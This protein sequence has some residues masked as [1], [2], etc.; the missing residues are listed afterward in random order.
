M[1]RACA[2]LGKNKESSYYESWAAKA[3]AEFAEEYVSS[4]GRLV[5]DTQTAYSLAI[6]FDLLKDSQLSRAGAQLAEIVR[7]NAF[8]VGTGFAGTPFVCEAL[9]RTGHSNVAY[10]MLLNETCPSWLYTISM[11]ATTTWERWDSM[12]PDGSINPGE[13]TSFN[14]YAYGAVAKFM[15][16]RLAGLQQLEPGWKRCRVQPEIG[17]EFTWASASHLTPYGTVSS[18]WKLVEN[19]V[20]AGTFSLSVD[21]EVPPS[22]TME[23]VLPSAEGPKTQ[24]V[25]SGKWS[26]TTS[27]ERRYEWPVK[28]IKFILARIHD[29]AQNL[30]NKSHPQE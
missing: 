23:V 9:T 7:R 1:A 27:Y 12:L 2:V 6:C 28:E 22:T 4:S 15:V 24:V 17:G 11:G 19:E 5:S 13:M 8:R 20:K 3:R 16:E 18:S 29:E 26:F 10:S 25:G 21:V 14:H 30:A